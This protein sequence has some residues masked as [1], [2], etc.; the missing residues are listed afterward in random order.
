MTV[1]EKRNWLGNREVGGVGQ[2]VPEFQNFW[3]DD[4]F[5]VGPLGGRGWECRGEGEV[6]GQGS[7]G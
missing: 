5:M 1:K 3:H 7:P 4:G 6:R 2:E